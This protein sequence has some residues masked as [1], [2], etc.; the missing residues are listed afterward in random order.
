M[1]E[2]QLHMLCVYAGP[3]AYSVSVV[4]FQIYTYQ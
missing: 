4:I 2:N 3:S 1:G